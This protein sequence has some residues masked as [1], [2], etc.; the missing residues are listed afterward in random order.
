MK[1]DTSLGA[2]AAVQALAASK[3]RELY[4]EG[5]GRKNILAFWVGEPDEPT[6]AFIRKAATESIGAGELSIRTTS[7]SRSC[8]RPLRRTSPGS[9]GQQIP[10][11]SQ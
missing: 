3:I 8:A 5:I 4:N 2:R 6:P 9:T 7:V 1:F 11:K 10:T